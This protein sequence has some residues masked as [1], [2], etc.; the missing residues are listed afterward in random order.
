[1]RVR[2]SLISVFAESFKIFHF[3][4]SFFAGSSNENPVESDSEE[5]NEVGHHGGVKN[6]ND[7]RSSNNIEFNDVPAPMEHHQNDHQNYEMPIVSQ[8][9]ID[10]GSNE[11]GDEVVV[12][13][14][15]RRKSPPV[16]I[17]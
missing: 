9:N 5:N 17:R 7:E 16:Q 2:G 12:E 8:S 14:K 13:A 4:F 15:R 3:T 6:I 1:M 11:S 10:V